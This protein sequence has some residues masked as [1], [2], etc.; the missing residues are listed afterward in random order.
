MDASTARYRVAWLDTSATGAALGR[1][2]VSTAEHAPRSAVGDD[3]LAHRA[4]AVAAAPPVPL[5][6]RCSIAMLN[7]L[8]YRTAPA[9]VEGVLEPLTSF[10]FPL[11]AVAGWNRLYGRRG[12]VQWQCVVPDG[13]DHVLT[14]VLERLRHRSYVTVLKRFGTGNAGP[15]SFPMA[16]WTLAVDVPAARPLGPVLDDLDRLVADAG[17]RIY[18]A[19]DARLD[20]GL[21]RAMYPR[22]DEWRAVRDRLD[23]SG[24]LQ[25]DLGRRR[26]LVG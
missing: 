17:G 25:S 24:A 23:P 22:L 2:V 13:A 11:D 12:L 5:V 9:R 16:G 14:T 19:K 6:G 10:F 20:P 1:G 26:G 4:R 15:L 21:V 3:P 8:R 18:L 7:A